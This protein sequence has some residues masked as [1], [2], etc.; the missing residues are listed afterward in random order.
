MSFVVICHNSNRKPIYL[1][2]S[3]VPDTQKEFNECLIIV[4][5][6][7]KWKKGRKGGEEGRIKV[8]RKINILDIKLIFALFFST[9][10]CY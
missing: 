9:G 3:S 10:E 2:T 8:I 1:V 5:K 4:R 6:E 7:I